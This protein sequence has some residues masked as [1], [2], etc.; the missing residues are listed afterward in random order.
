MLDPHN[1]LAHVHP[2]LVKVATAAWELSPTFQIV[3][4]LRTLAEEQQAVAAGHSTTL[5]SRHLP[6]AHYGGVA[7]AFD[8]AALMEGTISWNVALYPAVWGFIS[9]AAKELGVEIQWGGSWLTLKDYGHIQLP[10]ELY[11]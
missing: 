11:P 10:W 9:T 7:M 2:D 8:F 6:D 1:L 3:Y 4:G 5:H